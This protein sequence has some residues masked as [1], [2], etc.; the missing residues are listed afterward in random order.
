MVPSLLKVPSFSLTPP[1]LVA[2]TPWLSISP[3]ASIFILCSEIMLMTP[4]TVLSK[5]ELPDSKSIAA[6]SGTPVIQILITLLLVI[7]PSSSISIALCSSFSGDALIF[8]APSLVNTPSSSILKASPV[9]LFMFMVPV[10]SLWNSP[11]S[12]SIPSPSSMISEILTVPA[13][14]KKLPLSS[15]SIASLSSAPLRLKVPWLIIL[16][17]LSMSMISVSASDRLTVP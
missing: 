10:D 2:I 6:A 13:F 14:P 8:T 11:S 12:T 15:I 4:H 17:L 16:L 9:T 1:K 5:S 7:R 3:P